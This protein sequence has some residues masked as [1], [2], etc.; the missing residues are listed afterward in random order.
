VDAQGKYLVILPAGTY[1][2]RIVF[3]PN[4]VPA[5][6]SVTVTSAVSGTVQVSGDT[7]RNI[8]L[9]SVTLFNVSG[10]V[11]GLNN[12]PSATGQEISF[13]TSDGSAQGIFDVTSGS[14]QGVLPAGSYTAG[15]SASI[16]M[17]LPPPALLPI[18]QSL[19]IQLGSVTIS[20]N[21]AIPT[22]AVPE[23]VK[24]SGTVNNVALP[25]F[26]ISISATTSDASVY[27][28]VSA[29]MMTAIYQM[30]LPKN[31]TYGV[32]V[33][34]SLVSETTFLGLVNFPIPAT[35]IALNGDTANFNF[36]VPNLPDQVTISGR[37]IDS[38]N[39][40][41]SGAFISATS[42][43]LTGVPNVRFMNYGQTDANGNYSVTVRSGSNY[44][45]MFI[46]PIPN[47]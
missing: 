23:T 14:Y 13:T 5:G 31:R 37:V 34:V 6:A 45:L 35:S 3:M 11:T 39:N 47:Q 15:I 30:I 32:G 42:Q 26:G 7:T 40:P 33:G 28:S 41:V 21:T 8:A 46:P 10:S 44:Q 36:T 17:T 9:P 2:L 16:S 18:T 25:A 22:F 29:E 1:N 19:G 27:S 38:S 43:S 20:S 24:L 12:L 4:G